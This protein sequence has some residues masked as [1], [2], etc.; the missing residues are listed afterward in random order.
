MQSG[1]IEGFEKLVKTRLGV[2]C[3]KLELGWLKYLGRLG[4]EGLFGYYSNLFTSGSFQLEG[5]KRA[6]YAEFFDLP[7][8]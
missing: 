3:S 5:L 8:R 4:L 7:L 6:F 2:V 1:D